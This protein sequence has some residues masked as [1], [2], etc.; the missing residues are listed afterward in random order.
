[1]RH[2]LWLGVALLMA[3]GPKPKPTIDAGPDMDA[4]MEDG[5]VDAGRQRGDEPPAG[6][7]TALP[8][9]RDAGTTTR[10]GVSGAMALDQFAHP[11]VAAYIV[12]PNADAVYTDSRLVFTRWN[13]VTKA[14]Q[15]PL[16]VEIVG[17]IDVAHPNR[18]ISI[19]RN[20]TTGQIGIAYLNEL[21]VVRYGHSEDEGEHFS[22]ED[23][24]AP[25]TD[26]SK[27][28]NPVLAYAGDDLHIAYAAKPT[29]AMGTCGKIVHRKRT[30]SAGAWSTDEVQGT[31]AARDWPFA[32]ALDT[33]GAPAFAFFSEDVAGMVTLSYAAA[34]STQTI[35]TSS[36][37]VD[38]AAKTPSVSLT[39]QGDVPRVAFH[40]LSAT[41]ADAQL[42]Y[43]TKSAGAWSTP[44]ALPRNGPLGMLDTTQWYQQIVSEGGNKV[45]IVAN[46]Q[47]AGTIGQQ[48]GG[49]KLGRSNDGVAFTVCH[50]QSVGSMSS[51]IQQGGLWVNMASHRP[52]KLTM[53][54][55][56]ES[57]ANPS[58]E[59]GGGGVLLYR[60]P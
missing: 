24:S 31:L 60:E 3:C 45:A 28:S 10:Y 23:V 54:L 51:V 25:N 55:T 27:L 22:L 35:A 50:P 7:S 43:A 14:W 19:A 8:L 15:E 47:R 12:D 44:V 16:R 56:Y 34:G 11:M 42:W 53:T 41:N 37:M 38:T 4:G 26:S 17:N 58:L 29:C 52:A 40:L 21:G 39:L 46:F 6:W 48:C 49:P 9:P 5:G 13:G 2:A 20:P 30:G 57:N 18:Q 33:A 36:V 59:P 32:M 1:M